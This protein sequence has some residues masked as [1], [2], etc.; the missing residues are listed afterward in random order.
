MKKIAALFSVL[1][2]FAAANM[3]AQAPNIED[4]PGVYKCETPGAMCIM[5]VTVSG[6]IIKVNFCEDPVMP[7]CPTF[8]G[9]AEVQAAAIIFVSDEP[10]QTP[11]SADFFLEGTKV[12]AKVSVKEGE[13]WELSKE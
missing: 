4:L 8:S 3:Q 10:E 12:H 9:K 5:E 1:F 7:G 2:L 6:D 11:G 13:E